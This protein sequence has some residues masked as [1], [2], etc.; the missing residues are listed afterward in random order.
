MGFT[1]TFA[2]LQ[3]GLQNLSLFDQ[4]LLEASQ[5]IV[6]EPTVITG[7]TGTVAARTSAVAVQRNAPVSTSI[8]LPSV[9]SQGGMALRIFDWSTSVTEH[10]I[11]L[12]PDGTEKIMLQS[13]WPIVSNTV[14][15]AGVLLIPSVTLSGWYIAP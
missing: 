1:T 6:S 4:A 13:T 8:V 5:G 11:T 7:A 3:D 14:S 2:N 12:T 9:S 10:T 15:L